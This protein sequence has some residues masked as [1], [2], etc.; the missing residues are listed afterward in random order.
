[1]AAVV[2][3]SR[4]RA[5]P[6]GLRYKAPAIAVAALAVTALIRLTGPA[7]G[8]N[9]AQDLRLPARFTRTFLRQPPIARVTAVTLEGSSHSTCVMALGKNGKLSVGFEEL[10]PD[11]IVNL[12]ACD[13]YNSSREREST[14]L[15][16]GTSLSAR[17]IFLSGSYMLAAGAVMTASRY[18][19]THTSPVGDPYAR[20]EVPVYRNCTK[21]RYRLD[22]QKT[23]TISPGV[24]CGGIEVADGATLN[25]DPGTYILDQGNFAVSGNG[26]VNGTGITLILTSRTRTNYGAIDIRAGSTIELTAPS[27]GAEA[28]IPGIAIWVDGNN[29]P[30][31]S[32]TFDGAKAQNINGAIYLPSRQVRYSGGSPSATRCSQLIAQSIIFTGNS[33]FRHDCAGIGLSDPDP[34]TL[35]AE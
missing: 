22:E 23:E 34:S 12:A 18:L 21:I 25:L 31:T 1:M 6:A 20:L 9:P 24:Y 4:P 29:G 16:D 30:A 26:T 28:G 3:I 13:L 27:L 17:N 7:P 19:T 5:I 2:P 11:S 15:F 35:L 33:Y 14:E 8:T 32:D 10:S